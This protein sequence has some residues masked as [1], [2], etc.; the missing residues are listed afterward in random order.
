[1]NLLIVNDETISVQGM[2]QGIDW[3]AIGI[4]EVKSAFE[5]REA[6]EIIK[7]GWSVDII[8]C[9]IEMPGENGIEL[10]RWIVDS[11]YDMEKLILTCHPDF[12]FAQQAVSLG[13]RDYILTPASYEDIAE[14]I[15]KSVQ[16]VKDKKAEMEKLRYGE[17]WI[18]QYIKDVPDDPAKG[19]SE[20]AQELS[21]YICGHLVDKELSVGK[22]AKMYY[23]NADYL[24]RI[25]KKEKGVSIKQFIMDERMKLARTMLQ[26]KKY[27]V[28][29]I[30]S[31]VGYGNYPSFS[32]AF[33]NYYGVSPSE[34]KGE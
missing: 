24:N 9:D 21:I 11:G 32:T 5:A 1:M 14:K 25:F 2:I 17:M 15:G 12:A 13:V 3:D 7:T 6:K 16:I 28:Q 23:R 8:L 4:T 19:T 27:S 26:E 22:L 29:R 20:L 30:A 18:E 31:L 33:K 34:Y 10:L